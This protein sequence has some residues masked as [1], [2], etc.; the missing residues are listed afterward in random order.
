MPGGP[1]VPEQLVPLAY[2]LGCET[3]MGHEFI[4][5]PGV[6]IPR[7]VSGLVVRTA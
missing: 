1:G 2:V 4:A 6:I 7:E 3:F 5:E